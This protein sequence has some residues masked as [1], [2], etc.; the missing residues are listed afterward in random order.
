VCVCV[1]IVLI[2]L[3]DQNDRLSMLKIARHVNRSKYSVMIAEKIFGVKF[4]NPVHLP[5]LFL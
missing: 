5:V 1:V 3:S 4:H 2:S